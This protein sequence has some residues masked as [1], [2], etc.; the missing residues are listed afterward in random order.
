MLIGQLVPRDDDVAWSSW[1][2]RSGGLELGRSDRKCSRK[3]FQYRLFKGWTE[4]MYRSTATEER[5]V[6][7]VTNRIWWKL[8]FP[9]ISANFR[10]GERQEKLSRYHCSRNWPADIGILA[11]A[12]GDSRET[13]ENILKGE[14]KLVLTFGSA[15][16]WL[17]KTWISN[18]KTPWDFLETFGFTCG[19]L[20]Q[21]RRLS[22]NE[23][24]TDCLYSRDLTFG[25]DFHKITGF[26]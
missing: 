17:R 9:T 8:N 3:F 10:V 6:G 25:F 24:F 16:M 23:F 11:V 21:L 2:N 4:E 5:S 13:D 22:R 19:L 20:I 26:C 14:Y 7:F 15:E 1:V 18:F 12:V